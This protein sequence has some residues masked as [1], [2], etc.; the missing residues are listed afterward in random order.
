MAA[1]TLVVWFAMV[2][3]S[4]SNLAL[5]GK[6]EAFWFALFAF[7]FF[8]HSRAGSTKVVDKIPGPW[9]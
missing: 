7:V 4:A 1:L 9:L 5:V 3:T 2:L 8:F 6:R